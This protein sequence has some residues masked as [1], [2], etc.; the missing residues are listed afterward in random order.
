LYS[1][2]ISLNHAVGAAEKYQLISRRFLLISPWAI[3]NPG[4]LQLV[5][6]IKFT[7]IM[8]RPPEL[9]E[10]DFTGTLW[11]ELTH[12]VE[13]AHPKLVD[14]YAGHSTVD[15]VLSSSGRPYN[16]YK[17]TAPVARD[18]AGELL[19]DDVRDVISGTGQTHWKPEFVQS[20][21]LALTLDHFIYSATP[22]LWR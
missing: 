12:Y 9:Q 2:S 3:Q 7:E 21:R 20:L 6:A 17:T 22:F 1:D 8:R 13:F 16:V 5:R 19:A 4:L 15:W 18:S 10:S 11:H 14:F